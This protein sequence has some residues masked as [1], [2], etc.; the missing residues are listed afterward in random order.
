MHITTGRMRLADAPP[1]LRAGDRV[2]VACYSQPGG[3]IGPKG[4]VAQLLA[5]RYPIDPGHTD[6]YL[7]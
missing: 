4:G 2:R 5:G 6:P 7:L 3:L 1:S